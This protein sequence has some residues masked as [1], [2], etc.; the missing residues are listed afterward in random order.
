MK[1]S[2]RIV[3]AIAAFLMLIAVLAGCASDAKPEDRT[4]GET[5]E[6][7][8]P[9]GALS[10][11]LETEDQPELLVMSEGL[12][13]EADRAFLSLEENARLAAVYQ[14]D[15]FMYRCAA[16]FYYGTYDGVS[17]FFRIGVLTVVSQIDI[18]GRSFSFGSSFG[19]QAFTGDAF[20]SLADAYASG[21]ISELQLEAIHRY[22]LYFTEHFESVLLDLQGKAD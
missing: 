15:G 7:V 3:S 2:Y 18:G 19:L 20:T 9:K 13:E 12:K 5:D 22:H 21:L 16:G 17:V 8:F 6:F 11:R 1:L 4:A 10:V 14:P